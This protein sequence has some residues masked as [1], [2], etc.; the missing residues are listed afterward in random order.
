VCSRQHRLWYVPSTLC[1]AR[2][3]SQLQDCLPLQKHACM[4]RS[5]DILS[6]NRTEDQTWE[7]LDFSERIARPIERNAIRLNGVYSDAVPQPGSR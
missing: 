2:C 5:F 6:Q 4:Y 3:K 7:E 1:N